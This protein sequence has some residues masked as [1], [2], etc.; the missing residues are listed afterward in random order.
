MDTEKIC[1]VDARTGALLEEKMKKLFFI[2]SLCFIM[3]TFFACNSNTETDNQIP[4]N[5]NYPTLKISSSYSGYIY[6]VGLAGY[7]FDDLRIENNESK[8]FE[9]KNGIPGGNTNV[10][11]NIT[12]RPDEIHIDSRSPLSVKCNFQN[13]KTTTI[14]IP[15]GTVSISD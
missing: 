2:Y 8:S 6:R 12:F 10:N 3:L 4:A 9:L 1:Y 13:G 15:S 7:S 5:N 14:S 11:V